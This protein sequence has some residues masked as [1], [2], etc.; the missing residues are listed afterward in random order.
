MVLC[1]GFSGFSDGSHQV[2]GP[3]QGGGQLGAGIIDLQQ[4]ETEAKH[5]F[6]RGRI[7]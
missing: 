3:P 1:P 5:D 2:R 6:L 4:K 7:G